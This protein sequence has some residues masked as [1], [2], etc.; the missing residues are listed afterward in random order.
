V[1]GKTLGIVG[2]GRI[3]MAVALRAKAFSLNVK[4]YDPYIEFGRA[5]A[6]GITQVLSLKELLEQ[7]NI[8]S[9]HCPLIHNNKSNRNLI[10]TENIKYMQKGSFLINTARGGIVEEA[11][12]INALQDGTLAGVGID[13]FDPEPY[14]GALLKFPNVIA[15]PHTAFYS[16]EGVVEMRTKAGMSFLCTYLFIHNYHSFTHSNSVHTAMEVRR[17]LLGEPLLYC[18]NGQYFS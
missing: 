8:I 12:L 15:T 11:A 1:S 13:V 10:N 7:C 18:V 6:L 5:K 16:D 17:M 3:G 2:L 4:Y 9:I 14:N